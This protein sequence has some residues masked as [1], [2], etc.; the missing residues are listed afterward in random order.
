MACS[1]TFGRYTN[2]YIFLITGILAVDERITPL[3][4]VH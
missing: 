2:T 4:T 3:A 1:V